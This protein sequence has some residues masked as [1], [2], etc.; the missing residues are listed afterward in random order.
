MWLTRKI[1]FLTY[2]KGHKFLT[3]TDKKNVFHFFCLK[4]IKYIIFNIFLV[5]YM[6][7]FNRVFNW[8]VW[9]A[10]SNF[11]ISHS[12]FCNPNVRSEDQLIQYVQETTN[13]VPEQQSKNPALNP[14]I[15]KVFEDPR[16]IET[17][18]V[19]IDKYKL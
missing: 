3:I 18:I 17:M 11:L 2:N 4:L 7:I 10:T 15:L 13:S 16:V 8:K 19:M 5:T 12:C 1:Q 9:C 6:N 14:H